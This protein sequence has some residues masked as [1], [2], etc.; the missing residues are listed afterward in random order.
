MR[1]IF[2]TFI[3][4][5]IFSAVTYANEVATDFETREIQLTCALSSF[6][7]Y[8]DD[9]SSLIRNNL[10]S[11]GWKVDAVNT[12]KHGVKT[13]AYILGKTF[14]E[15]QI[16]KILVISGTEDMHDFEVDFR[17][18]GVKLHEDKSDGI[19]VHKGFRDYADAMLSDGFAE[20]LIDELKNNP[21]E[22]L[23]LTGHSLGGSVAIMTAIRLIDMGVDKDR[24]KVITFAAP[25]VGNKA[26]ANEYADKIDLTSIEI[27]GD[28]VRSVF[29]PFGYVQFGNIVTWT[30][31]KTSTNNEHKIAMYLDCA[32]RNYFDAEGFTFDA[33]IDGSEIDVPVYVAP[34]RFVKKN[35]IAEDEK[36]IYMILRTCLTARL[37]ALTFDETKYVEVESADN[38]STG[39]M[40]IINT[41][42]NSGC[43]YVLVQ[44]V[45]AE[46]VR[47]AQDNERKVMLYEF[48][49]D[50]SG[51]PVM[52]QTSGMST[53]DLTLIEAAFFAQ[54]NL[55][56]SLE[57]ALLGN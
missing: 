47:E 6:A 11:M 57:T 32:L 35:F 22:T 1:K 30:P 34:I 51:V 44:L 31:A 28:V 17:M 14:D 27:K 13:K 3:C 9:K 25:A 18:G 38:I 42:K 45:N 41:A 10:I 19:V 46:R 53:K 40:P 15:G 29:E 23:Y 49:V 2:L 50:L 8:S 52:M 5:I 20:S 12:K 36:Y 16:A 4:W 39:L 43:K 48:L 56:K 37:S 54:E 33:G 21:N 7:A 24:M 26:L 55:I